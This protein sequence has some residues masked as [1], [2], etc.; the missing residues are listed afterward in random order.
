[1]TLRVEAIY[2][3]GEFRP[4]TPVGLTESQQGTLLISEYATGPSRLD[5]ELVARASAE[6][7]AMERVPNI[8][9]VRRVLSKI[10][11]SLVDDVI[12]ALEDG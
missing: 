3:D 1:M 11:G 9:E 7:A 6:V 5:H 8:E 12:A 4:L 2:Q 10:L